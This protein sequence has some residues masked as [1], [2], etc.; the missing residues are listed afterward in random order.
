MAVYYSK[1]ILAGE[2]EYFSYREEDCTDVFAEKIA[3]NLCVFPNFPKQKT[4]TMQRKTIQVI[5]QRRLVIHVNMNLFK[6][7]KSL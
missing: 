2:N 7:I 4:I 3:E 1:E 5:G 6:M